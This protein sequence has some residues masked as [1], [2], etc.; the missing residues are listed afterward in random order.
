MHVRSALCIVLAVS[1]VLAGLCAYGAQAVGY[2]VR[3]FGAKGDGET[4]DTAAVQ[5]TI[6]AAAD[7]G[8][9]TVLFAAGTYLCGSLHLR[10][11]VTLSL[12]GGATIKGS[13]D[14]GDYDAIEKL[15]FKNDA[16]AETSFFH[17]ALIW[18]EDVERIA[19]VGEGSID[20]NRVRRHGPKT[21]AL[22]RCK[23]VTI[24]GVRLLNAPNYNISVLGTDF[25]DI[26]GVTILNGYADGIDPDACRNVRI[27]NCHI[28]SRDDAIVPKASFSLGERR[29][30]ENITVTNCYLASA[31]N[32]FKLGTESG[33]DF[34]RIAVSNCVM[35]AFAKDDLARGGICLESVDGSNIDGVVVTNTTMVD[36]RAPIFIRLGNRGRDMTT[37]VPGSLKNV[38]ISTVSATDATLACSVTGIPD[39]SVEGVTISDVRITWKGGCMY[40]PPEEAVPEVVAE[41]PDADMFDALPAYGF[42]CRHVKGLRLSNIDLAVTDGFWRLANPERKKTNWDT[43][44]GI[45]QPSKPGHP[46]YALVCDDV[47]GL[48]VDGF[49]AASDPD[50]VPVV[51]LAGVRG[52][53]LRG[54]VAAKG[55]KVFLEAAGERT[56]GITLAGCML[57]G[58]E[59]AV[60][61]A[62]GAQAAAVAVRGE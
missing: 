59:K 6:D 49:T 18:G 51:R 40:R 17:S 24:R 42:Y 26:D 1:V 13:P 39:K 28:E 2:Q 30:C 25:V 50:G 16:D 61:L 34:K 56:G 22:K 27:S 52:A 14:N 32:C 5:K 10:N 45:P 12:D 37:P 19:I 35:A 7:A 21:I 20:S 57:D 60:G 47:S 3:D 54:C 44:D 46:G 41:Y 36:V 4:K 38:V 33:G 53:L 11:G 31:A 58:A 62:S 48:S 8:G 43:P 23:F 15:D 55:T 9:G 29:S